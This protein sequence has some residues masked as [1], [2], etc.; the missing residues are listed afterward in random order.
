M[1]QDDIHIVELP[2]MR[3]ICINGYGQEPENQAFEK[4]FT[5]AK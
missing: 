1:N 2:A 4:I 3:V 5:W